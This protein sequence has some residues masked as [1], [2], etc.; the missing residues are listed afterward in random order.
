MPKYCGASCKARTMGL[1]LQAFEEGG[2]G[3]RAVAHRIL[4]EAKAVADKKPKSEGPD[5]RHAVLW[6]CCAGLC[7]AVLGYAVQ[8]LRGML[9]CAVLCCAG[10]CCAMLFSL[11]A[12]CWFVLCCDVPK[13]APAS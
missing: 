2:G 3:A 5:P 11:C 12:A 7:C 1:P 13:M 4:A 9:V 6:M 8:V 10:L